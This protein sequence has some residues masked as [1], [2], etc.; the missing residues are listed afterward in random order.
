MMGL[1]DKPIELNYC[2]QDILEVL[3]KNG[4]GVV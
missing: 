2:T 1:V 4:R 3:F